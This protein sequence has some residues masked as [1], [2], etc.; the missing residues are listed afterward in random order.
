MH[1]TNESKIIH[2]S[3][4]VVTHNNMFGSEKLSAT[5]SPLNVDNAEGKS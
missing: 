1:S 5:N 3:K 2:D 4:P